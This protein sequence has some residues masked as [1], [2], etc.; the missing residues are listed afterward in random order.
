M[1]GAGGLLNDQPRI[2]IAGVSDYYNVR[3]SVDEG[4]A[5]EYLSLRT[6]GPGQH[7]L[8][9]NELRSSGWTGWSAP[10]AF[11][12]TGAAPL[13]IPA[14][15][16]GT[17]ADYDTSDACFA[18]GSGGI[19]AD[20]S[21]VIWILGVADWD[22]VRYSVD[23][24]PASTL[25]DLNFRTLAAGFHTIR[26][27]EQQAAGWT[28]W[29]E[30][31]AFTL[32]GAAPI[33]ITAMCDSG[34]YQSNDE[35]LAAG[36][37]GLLAERNPSIWRR[38]TVNAANDQ[39]S[40]DGGPA[41]TW[42]DFTLRDLAAGRHQVRVSEQQP[43][44]WT[45]WSEPYWF[46]VTGA[47]PAEVVAFCDV[48]ENGQYTWEECHAA[49]VTRRGRHSLWPRGI[50][51]LDNVRFSVD[52]G[53]G[54]AWADLSLVPLRDGRHNVRIAEQQPAGWT[55]WSEPYWFTIQE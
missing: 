12:V 14:V 26:A 21:P 33:E 23:G 47:A 53:A 54:V 19:L 52:A 20:S 4:G 11:T 30:P 35:C 44:G 46:T 13:E 22:N 45:G 9:V 17:W 48:P 6:L 55:G 50:V 43:A 31:Y 24:G 37:N 28:G 15:C 29:S 16:N 39:Y 3:Y 5:S 41:V 27:S 1:A 10:Y 8:R 34:A 42:E 2:F 36:E 40:I 51:D 18:A 25:D 32:T 38:G 49:P 7:A